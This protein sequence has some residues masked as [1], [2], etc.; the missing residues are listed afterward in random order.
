MRELVSKTIYLVWKIRNERRIGNND[1]REREMT[2]SDIRN[3]WTHAI[4]KRLTI[5]RALT[6]SARFGKR[7]LEKTLVKST[8]KHCLRK[9]DELPDE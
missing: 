4:N 2:D 8:W 6:N 9:E 5:D 3:R 7:A 1:A